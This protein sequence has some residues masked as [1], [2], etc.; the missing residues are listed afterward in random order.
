MVDIMMD[1]HL[2]EAYMASNNIYGDSAARVA[3]LFYEAVYKENGVTKQEFDTSFG[4][5]LRH[6][7]MMEK[8]EAKVISRLNEGN[9][10]N[11]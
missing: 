6:P 7:E 3:P 11:N 8:I 4:F 5:Y 9:P 1:I 10:S 2:S